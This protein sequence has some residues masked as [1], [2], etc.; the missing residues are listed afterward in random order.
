LHAEPGGRACCT[1]SRFLPRSP[2]PSTACSALWL[3][4]RSI[5]HVYNRLLFVRVFSCFQKRVFVTGSR[6]I[7]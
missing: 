7:R 5:V 3:F 2:F 6:G 1:Y 4:Q